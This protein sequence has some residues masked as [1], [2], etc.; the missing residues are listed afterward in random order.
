MAGQPSGQ[1]QGPAE[2]KPVVALTQ[3]LFPEVL[4]WLQAHAEVWCPQADTVW[5]PG[6]LAQAWRDAGLAGRLKGLLTTPTEAVAEPLLAE[7]PALEVVSQMAVGYNNID[8]AACA[9]RQVAVAHTPDVLTETTAD[10]AMAMLLAA[11]R[12]ITDAERC[13]R[14]GQW[15]QWS[16]TGFMGQEVHGRTLGIIGMGRIG[17]ALA[18]RAHL[19]F[20]MRVTYHQRTPLPPQAVPGV[21]SQWLP[22]DELLAV[23]DHV[24]LLVPHGPGTHHLINETRLWQMRP[25]ATLCNLARGGVVDDQA[26]ARVMA[27]GHLAGAALDVFEG[28]PAVHAALLAQPRITLTPHMASATWATR[29]AMAWMAARQLLAGLGLAEA[30][31]PVRW[32]PGAT[33]TSAPTTLS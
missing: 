9:K 17:L 23:A 33:P 15:Q 13:L 32:V 16:P 3:P 5:A 10:F 20:G 22:L 1:A 11:A 7:L 12:G 21:P 8:V 4:A 30:G 14:A 2:A 18:R 19:G 26:L 31:E 24:V 25:H 29:Q 28:E 6:Q 27:A